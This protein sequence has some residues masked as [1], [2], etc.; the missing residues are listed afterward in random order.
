[1]EQGAVYC[2][3]QSRS[4]EILNGLCMRTSEKESLLAEDM[5][6]GALLTNKMI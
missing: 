1:M 6:L 5:E 2:T 4:L 3:C